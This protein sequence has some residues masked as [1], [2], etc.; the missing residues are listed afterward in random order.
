MK[1]KITYRFPIGPVDSDEVEYTSVKEITTKEYMKI[2]NN[3]SDVLN[4]EIVEI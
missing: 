4:I 3:P 1:V 2:L